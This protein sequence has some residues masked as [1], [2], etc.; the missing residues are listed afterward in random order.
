MDPPTA[1][2]RGLTAAVAAR[3]GLSPTPPYGPPS[4]ERDRALKI[5]R[6]SLLLI[7]LLYFAFSLAQTLLQLEHDRGAARLPASPGPDPGLRVLILNRPQLLER[8]PPKGSRSFDAL[9]VQALVPCELSSPD[10]PDNPDMRV[11]L[12]AGARL[13]VKP[14]LNSGLILSSGDF[15]RGAK[16]LYWTVSRVWLT[17]IASVPARDLS[18][19]SRLDPTGF[20]AAGTVSAFAIGRNRY[21]GSLEIRWTGSKEISAVN[22][23]PIE[24]YLEGVV[25]EEM[26]PGWPLEALKAQAMV[27]RGYAYARRC[28]ARPAEQWFD[29]Q[30]GGDDQ[31]Y[32]GATGIDICRR[33]VFETRG[34]VPLIHG[35]P[36]LPLFHASSG[37]RIGGVE[38]VWSGARDVHGVEPL[39][40]VMPPQDDPWCSQAVQALGWQSTHGMSTATIDPREL[41]REL[42][43]AISST[44]RAIGYVKDIK[45]CRRDPVSQRV[46]SILV[47]HSQG[48]P[49]E[50]PAHVFRRLVGENILRSTLWT[51]ESPRKYESPTKRGHFLYDITCYGWG[52]GAGMSQVS[53]WLMARQGFTA[54]RIVQRFYLGTQLGGLW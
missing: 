11:T 7:L 49:I 13:L 50:V 31:E 4:M 25:G 8:A 35:H 46:L 24:A 14:E 41:Q 45:V 38:A 44:G 21:R 40:A 36:F 43:K 37:G 12:K 48:D 20:E 22:C 1:R 51:P 9:Y 15:D 6:A 5:A 53:A 47:H 2:Q 52:H 28:R 3:H 39:A 19:K 27:S 34:L 30:D 29:L 26:S 54:E 32:R 16:E 42:G 18:S 23:L 10:T 17:P 33:A